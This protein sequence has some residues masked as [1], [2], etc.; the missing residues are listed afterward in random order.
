ME[1]PQY[2][3]Y[4][5]TVVSQNYSKPIGK[6]PSPPPKMQLKTEGHDPEEK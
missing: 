6:N 4:F 1:D 5:A 2:V 3:D